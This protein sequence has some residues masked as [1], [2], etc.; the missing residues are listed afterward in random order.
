MPVPSSLRGARKVVDAA[1][2]GLTAFGGLLEKPLRGR[3]LPGAIRGALG[4]EAAA[5]DRP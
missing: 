3:E 5:S 1:R 4:H 2:A